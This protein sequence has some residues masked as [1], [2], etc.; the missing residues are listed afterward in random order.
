MRG[1]GEHEMRGGGEHEMR[2]G[3][4]RAM[5]GGE[6]DDREMA[7]GAAEGARS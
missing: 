4:E 2:G 3:G 1:G 7:G 6:R 5:R